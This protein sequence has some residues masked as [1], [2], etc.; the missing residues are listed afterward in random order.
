VLR[1]AHRRGGD[2]V[3]AH[4]RWV[5][6]VSSWWWHGGERP[7]PP[8]LADTSELRVQGA[9]LTAAR[10]RLPLSRRWW[11]HTRRTASRCPLHH[12]A[13]GRRRQYR[14]NAGDVAAVRCTGRVQAGRQGPAPQ[15]R[16]SPPSTRTPAAPHSIVDTPAGDISLGAHRKAWIGH[17]QHARRGRGYR[18]QQEP[19]TVPKVRGRIGMRATRV[20]GSQEVARACAANDSFTERPGGPPRA[21]T[22]QPLPRHGTGGSA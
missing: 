16:L 10:T 2:A 8:G 5:P 3:H 14:V 21:G 11:R 20:L 7:V 12:P 9:A 19:A 17:C 1:A 15:Q 6:D 22:W 13:R 4:R 18:S